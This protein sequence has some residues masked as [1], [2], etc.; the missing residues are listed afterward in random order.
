M[1]EDGGQFR[2]ISF[3]IE[4]TISFFLLLFH[5]S[6]IFILLPTY[7]LYVLRKLKPKTILSNTLELH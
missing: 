4:P 1:H 7:T 5:Q 2:Q 6:T 3:K